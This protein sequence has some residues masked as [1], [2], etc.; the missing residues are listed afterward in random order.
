MQNAASDASTRSDGRNESHYN[1]IVSD[2]VSLIARVQTSM[3]L[4]ESAIAR[5]APLGNREIS[6]NLVVL[7]DVTPGY[8]KANA[9]LNTC[10]A[11]LGVALHFLMDAEASKHPS[12]KYVECVHAPVRSTTPA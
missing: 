6:A 1:S 5:E 7:D 11:G 2:L 3:G 4:I 10:H 9:A 8:V 12:G